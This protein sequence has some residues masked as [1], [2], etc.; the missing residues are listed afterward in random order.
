[1]LKE[2]NNNIRSVELKDTYRLVESGY[3]TFILKHIFTGE[4][5]QL[6]FFTKQAAEKFATREGFIIDNK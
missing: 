1:M 4:N 2:L 3:D 5:I 6:S